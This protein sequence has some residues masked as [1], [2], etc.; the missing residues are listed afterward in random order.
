MAICGGRPQEIGPFVAG[1]RRGL[2]LQIGHLGAVPAHRLPHP[3]VEG[4]G[5]LRFCRLAQ[6]EAFVLRNDHALGQEVYAQNLVLNEAVDQGAEKF[7][8]VV[9]EGWAVVLVDVEDAEVGAQG[10][11]KRT[12]PHPQIERAEHPFSPPKKNT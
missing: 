12:K 5:E 11:R 7:D 8:Q 3:G 9:S 10:L 1:D 4:G 2:P 6:P